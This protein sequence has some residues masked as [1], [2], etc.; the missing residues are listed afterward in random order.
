MKVWEHRITAEPHQHTAI[1]AEL[2][3]HERIVL[4]ILLKL[5]TFKHA[6]PSTDK[7]R[8]YAQLDKSEVKAA[9]ASLMSKGLV[10]MQ[11]HSE[12]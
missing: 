12:K 2:P 5:D 3:D 11:K 4:N 6:S 8:E 9:L 7:I 10:L 1:T